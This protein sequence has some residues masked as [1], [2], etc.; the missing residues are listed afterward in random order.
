MPASLFY[1]A[2]EAAATR[3][4]SIHESTIEEESVKITEGL[5]RSNSCRCPVG[6]KAAEISEAPEIEGRQI[7]MAI[8]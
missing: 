4:D 1:L 5:W 2:L 8:P 7:R 3:I 6:A